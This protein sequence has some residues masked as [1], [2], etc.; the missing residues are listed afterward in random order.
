MR[1]ELVLRRLLFW[2]AAALVVFFLAAAITRSAHDAAALPRPNFM[3]L[4]VAF[5][6]FLLHYF[7]QAIGA[8]F[9]L[10]ALGQRVPMR[11]SIRAWYLSVIARWMPGRIWYFSARGYF[12]RESGVA[13]PA[14]TIAILLELTYMLMGGF[15]VVGAFAGATLRGV[16]ANNIGRAG[17]GAAVLVLVCAGAV[18]IRPAV[19]V[20]ACRF[21]L[22]AA[23]F[24]RITGRTANLDALPT[25]P[26]WRSMA[27]LTYYTLYWA[28][29]GLTFGVLARALGPMTRARWFACVPAFAGS[30]LAGYFSIIAPAGLGVREGA[31][32]LMLRPVMPQSHALM[33]AI[34]S[35]AMMLLAETVSVALTWLFLGSAIRKLAPGVQEATASPLQSAES[36]ANSAE[37]LTS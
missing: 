3:W 1:A 29:S 9:I 37:P 28:Y 11:L 6:M 33:L 36:V 32:W 23:A 31:M 14:F 4:T 7:V 24:R 19:L 22:A 20:R 18:A 12:A 17:L 26:A 21:R 10:R 5:V 34:A 30:W 8:H 15:I 13:I 25:M 16:L 27:L 2:L 35:R